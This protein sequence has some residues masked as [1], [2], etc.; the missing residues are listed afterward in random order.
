MEKVSN[1]TACSDCATPS[2]FAADSAQNLCV[3]CT[4][5]AYLDGDQ[6]IRRAILNR[7]KSPAIAHLAALNLGGIS[8]AARAIRALG[9]SAID[10]T[11]LAN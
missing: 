4:H 5:A 3:T 10:G 8:D 11:R 1:L 9:R 6:T 2:Q 7:A